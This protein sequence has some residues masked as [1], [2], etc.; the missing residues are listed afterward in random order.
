MIENVV[1]DDGVSVREGDMDTDG[2]PESVAECV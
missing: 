2:V 1:D